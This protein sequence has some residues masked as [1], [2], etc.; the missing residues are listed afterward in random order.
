MA[1]V[2]LVTV[3]I[4]AQ[5]RAL[6]AARAASPQIA[7]AADAIAA[8]LRAGGTLHYAGAGTSGRLGAIDAAELP[9]TF[10]VP[11]S[12]ARA[13]IAGGTAAF[14]AAV[15]GAEDDARGFDVEIH[16]KDGV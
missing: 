14:T 1:T 16:S 3:L 12:L 6:D 13:H 11:H 9:P 5:R 10:G 2:D 7:C 15:E 8:R 4:D